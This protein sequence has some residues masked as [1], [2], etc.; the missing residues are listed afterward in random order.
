MRGG[1]KLRVGQYPGQEGGVETPWGGI[2]P[3][4]MPRGFGKFFTYFFK[5]PLH[6]TK[7][8]NGDRLRTLMSDIILL[9]QLL[10]LF[11]HTVQITLQG[12]PDIGVF[13]SDQEIAAEIMIR[14]PDLD[15]L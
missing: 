11:V 4:K 10:R 5:Q 7:L 8:I 12:K 15:H 6:V 2:R 9:R 14:I 3:C 13:R 1:K